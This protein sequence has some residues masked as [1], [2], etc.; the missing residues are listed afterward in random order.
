MLHVG[1]EAVRAPSVICHSQTQ[2]VLFCLSWWQEC[3]RVKTDEPLSVHPF[4][5]ASQRRSPWCCLPGGCQRRDRRITLGVTKDALPG[6]CIV[7]RGVVAS[8]SLGGGSVT[9]LWVQLCGGWGSRVGSQLVAPGGRGCSQLQG[10]HEPMETRVTFAYRHLCE[11]P[12]S[13]GTK[14]WKWHHSPSLAGR[15]QQ[16][17]LTL[18]TLSPCWLLCPFP[19]EWVWLMGGQSTQTDV[20]VKR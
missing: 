5:L 18:F 9:A 6:A 19:A 1:G 14:G 16:R 11:R 4:G 17:F 8:I 20:E 15:R 12:L 10:L 2:I 13:V 7:R 3:D